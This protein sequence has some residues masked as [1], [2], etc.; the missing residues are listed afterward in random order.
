[1]AARK[2]GTVGKR[3][4]GSKEIAESGSEKGNSTDEDSNPPSNELNAYGIRTARPPE[5]ASVSRTERFL[6][7]EE[8]YG[9]SPSKRSAASSQRSI[10]YES[11]GDRGIRTE[12]LNNISRTERNL[13]ESDNRLG[14]PDEFI[15]QGSPSPPLEVVTLM[16]NLPKKTDD[17]KVTNLTC[18]T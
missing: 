9:K 11:E 1:M 18:H 12:Q 5:S 17:A 13:S 10:F 15:N 4:A 16:K 2:I 3:K 8:D 6:S 7:D 14:S